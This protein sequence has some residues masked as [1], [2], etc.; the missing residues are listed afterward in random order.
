MSTPDRVV[1]AFEVFLQIWGR[2]KY[3]PF[4]HTRAALW[5]ALQ[6]KH[7]DL[8]LTKVGE[9]IEALGGPMQAVAPLAEAFNVS[10]PDTEDVEGR[11]PAARQPSTGEP[12]SSMPDES[13]SKK[14]RS[15]A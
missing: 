13:A 9:L 6:R 14:R 12:T 11:P 5:A 15:G 2:P 4:K 8:T 10:R 7:P 1:S 3:P